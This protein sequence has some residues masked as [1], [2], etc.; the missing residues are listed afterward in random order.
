MQ[1]RYYR[2]F[3]S[4]EC[5]V[6]IRRKPASKYHQVRHSTLLA[7][8][9]QLDLPDEVYNWLVDYF[10]H[11]HL[12]QYRG[13]TSTMLPINAS[14]VQ[15]SGIGPA[16]YVVNAADL[17]TTTPGNRIAKYAED[18]YLIIPACNVQSRAIELDNV[19]AWAK[20]NNLRLNR[21]KSVEIVVTDGRRRRLADPPPTLHDV[22]RVTS[23]K[24]L[25]VTF[26]CKLS[27]S[28]HVS[29]IV[30][31]CAPTLNA[32]RVLRSHGMNDAALQTIYI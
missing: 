20:V 10:N 18:T 22:S 25:G 9:A 11:K 23:V 2:K 6:H 16:S 32:L 27:L 8:L 3:R 1:E 12:T 21:H 17:R 14:I 4:R 26:S 19:D 15:G 24:I 7:K 29:V 30:S 5:N 28:E 13:A 31:A